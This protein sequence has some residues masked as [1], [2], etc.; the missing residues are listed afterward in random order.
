MKERHKIERENSDNHEHGH[1]CRNE[2]GH[3]H[4]HEDGGMGC[5]CGHSHGEGGGVK[6][7]L[8]QLCAAFAI[9]AIAAFA[10][11]PQYVRAA[12]FAAAYLLAGWRVLLASLRNI[13]RGEV[14]DENFLMSVA[15]LGAF[16]IGDMAEAVAV[17]IFYGIGEMLQDSAVAKSKR[18]IESL[19]DLRSDYA[20]VLRGGQLVRVAPEEVMVGETVSVRP[21]EKIPLDGTVVSGTSF[22]DTRA[23][24]GESVPRRAAP[25]DE[26]LSGSVSTDGA[27]EIRVTKPFSESAVSK[28]L[29]LVRGAAAKKSATER[30]IT[31]FARWYTPTVVALAVMVALLPPLAGYGSYS[32]W[33]YKAL[34]FLIISCPCALV[35]SIPLS[36]FGGI[37]GAARNGILVKGSTYLE[38]MSKLGTIAFDKTGTLT[39]GVFKVTEL[40]PAD[41]VSQD[42]LLRYAAAAEAQSNHPIAKSVMTAF[43]GGTPER[44]E[45][46]EIA[47]MGVE[48]RTKEG[49]VR[50]GNVKLMKSI[51]IEGLREYAKSA[52]YV[53]LDGKFL[54]TLLVADE[55]KPG[56][57]AAMDDLRAAG[58][59]RLVMLTGDNLAIAKETAAEAGMDAVSAELLPQ[60]KTAELERLMAGEEKKTAF[61]G[62]GINDAPVLTRADI[63]IAMGGIGSDAAIE[64]ADVVIMTDEIDKIAA[65]IRI[66]VK[67]RWIVWENIVMALGFKIA[68]MLLAVF[69]DASVWFA[70]F[71]D[72]GV[73]L[74]AVAN[75]LR[76]LKA[77]A[78]QSGGEKERGR[79]AEPCPAA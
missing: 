20:S 69:A 26:V 4:G 40:L 50:A 19:M 38:T 39:R 45:V 59:S 1:S 78:V 11:L 6:G 32:V 35:L 64:A 25:N 9:A 55:L 66:A 5:G 16:A 57:R 42:E 61:V 24:T 18:S 62:D 48:A 73:A 47:G 37:G 41:G 60:D 67:T 77:P 14:F 56:V 27:L 79:G 44:A 15:S 31:K 68:V 17:M 29:E 74:L 21:G 52:V 70:I 43:G 65:A 46:R 71:A 49:V 53:A 34:S 58:V 10:P 7:T 8:I 54:G 23:L 3:D 22:L 12:G 28:I 51:G 75:A 2:H 30:F 76:A 72:V 36:F 13:S 63:G 33:F